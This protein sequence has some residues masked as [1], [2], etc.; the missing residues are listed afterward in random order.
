[1]HLRPVS[2]TTQSR[3]NRHLFVCDMSSSTSDDDEYLEET[4]PELRVEP[5]RTMDEPPEEPSTMD[6]RTYTVG[7][8]PR[9]SHEH[10]LREVFDFLGTNEPWQCNLLPL[11]EF[12]LTAGMYTAGSPNSFKIDV[13]LLNVADNTRMA[14]GYVQLNLTSHGMERGLHLDTADL[15]T[16]TKAA[17]RMVNDILVQRLGASPLTALLPS[18][19]RVVLRDVLIPRGL[20]K[21]SAEVTVVAEGVKEAGQTNQTGLVAYYTRMGFVPRGAAMRLRS[22][23]GRGTCMQAA[24][25]A[26]VLRCIQDSGLCRWWAKTVRP[27]IDANWRSVPSSMYAH[28]MYPPTLIG[29]IDWDLIPVKGDAPWLEGQASPAYKYVTQPDVI[30]G[31]EPL[32]TKRY[33]VAELTAIA[34]RLLQRKHQ[35]EHDAREESDVKQARMRA[36]MHLLEIHLL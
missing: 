35:T 11:K 15:F 8:H 34:T 24:S 7:V 26:H 23:D 12:R 18:I 33:T 32:V 14:F 22:S 13:H 31:L 29:H 27:D 17:C 9:S 36:R 10:V 5:A 16:R 30:R 2:D 3:S 28:S 4:H 20:V 21:P 1:M 25:I 6:V 19:M